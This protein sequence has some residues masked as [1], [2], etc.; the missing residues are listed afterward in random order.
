MDSRKGCN[1]STTSRSCLKMAHLKQRYAENLE[2][3][4]CSHDNSGK[5]DDILSLHDPRASVRCP[6]CEAQKVRV[7]PSQTLLDKNTACKVLGVPDSANRGCAR[8]IRI[9]MTMALV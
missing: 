2:A 3:G 1:T 8:C 7:Y 4:G 9:W 6:D 5:K